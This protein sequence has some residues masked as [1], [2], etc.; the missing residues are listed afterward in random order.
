MLL[1]A[2]FIKDLLIREPALPYLAVKTKFLS[3]A[4][5]KAAFNQLH[6]LLKARLARNS[7]QNMDMIRHNHEVVNR[8]FP[9]AH[10]AS[11]NFDKQARHSISLEE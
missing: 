11:K 4:E 1:K 2:P 3:G 9:R 10:I 5:R 6:R 7:H 8:D